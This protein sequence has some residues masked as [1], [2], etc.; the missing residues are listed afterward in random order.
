[1]REFNKR[2][3]NIISIHFDMVLACQNRCPYCYKL[4]HLDNTKLLNREVFD[5]VINQINKL[6]TERPEIKII[7]DLIG[8]EPLLVVDNVV[9]FVDKVSDDGVT[10]EVITNL[11]FHKDSDNIQK[12]IQ[13]HKTNKNFGITVTLHES[14]NLEWVKENIL[15]CADFCTANLLVSDDNI[16]N[17]YNDYLWLNENGVRYC[18]EGIID[19]DGDNTLTDFDCSLFKE[20]VEFSL[21]NKENDTIDD[22][23]FTYIES[24]E[25]DFLNISKRYFTICR[26]SQL[27][28][29]YHGEINSVCGY[30]YKGGHV[31]DGLKTPDLFCNGYSCRCVTTA[32]KKLGGERK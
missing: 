13:L 5:E 15:L 31:R 29:G 9:E 19:D 3:D 22:Q 14:S 8:G 4:E 18:V 26:L 23:S 7:V 27:V 2:N 21:D 1:M 32:Y 10:I 28:I 30:D 25:Q 12:I 16:D 20:I 17:V 6:K 24:L 11:N